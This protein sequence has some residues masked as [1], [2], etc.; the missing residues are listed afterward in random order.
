MRRQTPVTGPH[1]AR[2]PAAFLVLLCAVAPSLAARSVPPGAAERDP[3]A[4]SFVEAAV[5]ALGGD[6]FLAVKAVQSTGVYTAFIQGQR[7]LPVEF[8]DTF[9]YPD[10][11]RTEFGKKK[12]RFIQTNAGATGW[13][14]DASRELLEEQS[15]DEIKRFRE[16]SRVALENLLRTAL[17]DQGV[18]IRFIG[19]DEIAPRQRADGI[20][21]EFPDGFRV[22]AYFDSVSKLPALVRYREGAPEGAGQTV[23]LR[24]HTFVEHAGVKL[25]RVVDFYKDGVQTGRAVVDDAVV[26][27]SVPPSLFAKP[28]SAKD[29]K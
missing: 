4:V 29:L 27:P 16:G 6:R 11:E 19:R 24:F 3:K 23:E 5:A 26:D 1:T 25:P 14:F 7:G 12:S 21:I 13:K 28:A 17:R 20:S 2:G 9:V 8:V 22:E 18:A 10:H 15:E